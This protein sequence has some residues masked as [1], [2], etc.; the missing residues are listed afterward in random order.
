MRRWVKGLLFTGLGIIIA[1]II[2]LFIAFAINGFS[3]KRTLLPGQPK[4][5]AKINTLEETINEEFSNIKVDLGAADIKVEKAEDGICRVEYK[6]RGEDPHL[7]IGVSSDVFLEIGGSGNTLEIKQEGSNVDF[8]WE[9]LD[10]IL[11]NLYNQV[12]QSFDNELGT[13]VIYLPEKEYEIFD[14]YTLS[15]EIESV[16]P[17]SCKEANLHTA[18]GDLQLENIKGKSMLNLA[19]ASG[20]LSIKNIEG[21]ETVNIAVASGDVAVNNAAFSSQINA[22]TTSGEM[23]LNQVAVSGS[24]KLE[25]TSGAIRL[26]NT[27]F[28]EGDVETTSGEIYLEYAKAEK[29]LLKTTSGDIVGRIDADINVHGTTTSG[30]YSAPSGTKGEWR[31]ETTSGDVKLAY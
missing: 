13:L 27:E 15:G 23:T 9:H 5:D 19:A 8:D 4:K 24:A 20:D 28:Q 10:Q 22:T 16:H 6:Y 21:F 18:S 25:S 30:D 29:L 31:T 17:I 2:A 7:E 1:G 14:I 12:N 26:I 11:D 3:W